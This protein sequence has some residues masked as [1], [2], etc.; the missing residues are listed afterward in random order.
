MNIKPSFWGIVFFC[1]LL[2]FTI[3]SINEYSF[4]YSWNKTFG[5][6]NDDYGYSIQQTNDGGYIIVGRTESFGAGG[7]DVYLIKTD[8]S[9]NETWSQTFGGT[10]WD[11]GKTVQQTNDGGYIIVG[12]TESLGAGGNDVYLLYY[13]RIA[14][15]SPNG[16]ENL[17]E[18]ATHEI[19]WTSESGIAN[20]KIEYSVDNGTGWTEIVASTANDGSFNWEV[21]CDLSDEAL[22]RISDVDGGAS[23]TSDAVF[24]IV[25]TDSDGDG[26][27]DCNDTCTN[28]GICNAPEDCTTC[29]DDCIGR[30]KG[31]P[32]LRY[33]CGDEVCEG[34][35]DS[36]TCAVDCGPPPEFGDGVCEDSEICSCPDDCNPPSFETSCS[37]EDRVR[38]ANL[39]ED[40]VQ[41]IEAVLAKFLNQRLEGLDEKVNDELLKEC[42]ERSGDNSLDD[43]GA[44]GFILKELWKRLRETHKL[45]IVE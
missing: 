26:I 10:L 24:F 42:K 37:L 5:G 7:V 8:A 34:E 32:T 12:R 3:T 39:S 20:V 21:P 6:S 22:V 19:T 33:C 25:D 35:E 45:R 9:G 2:V 18:G 14:V 36:F 23:D 4:G 31:K 29:P 28:D 11:D 15:T 16:G 38:F 40:E 13:N 27:Y 43:A 44:S 30:M 17:S 1:T 41:V